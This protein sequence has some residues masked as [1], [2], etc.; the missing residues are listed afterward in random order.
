MGEPP[1]AG[2]E[3]LSEADCQKLLTRRNFGRI[4]LTIDG[5]PEVF[6]VN[7]VADD[8]R[9]VFRTAEGTRLQNSAMRRVAFEIDDWDPSAGVGWSVM[10]KGVAQEITDAIDHLASALRELPVVPLAPG[11]RERWLAVYPS[12]VTGRRFRVP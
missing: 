11:K 1:D 6:P 3:V 2:L 8:S 5:Q 9:I 4:A 12:E 7:Y 10:V